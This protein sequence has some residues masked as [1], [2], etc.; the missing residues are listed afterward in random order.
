M[1]RG[2]AGDRE[3]G[4]AVQFAFRIEQDRVV[5]ARFQAFGCPHLLAAASWVTEEA[6]RG[7]DRS[8]LAAWDWREAAR[9]AARCRR[10]NSGACSRCRTQYG[11]SSGTGRARPGLRCRIGII[12]TLESARKLRVL[13]KLAVG[14]AAGV[15]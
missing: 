9:G 7:L 12:G 1:V 15:T 8:Q 13:E 4:A 10:P 6:A 2:R 3:Q 14:M 11:Q 5:E